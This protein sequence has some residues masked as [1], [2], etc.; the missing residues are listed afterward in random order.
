MKYNATGK[1]EGETGTRS[2]QKLS[3]ATQSASISTIA[4]AAAPAA[5]PAPAPAAPTPAAPAAT[6]KRATPL[7]DMSITLL[8]FED[9]LADC[10]IGRNELLD[11]LAAAGA[12]STR[13]EKLIANKGPVRVF[14]QKF[15]LE[16]AIGFHACS[17][18]AS[19]RV[20]IGTPLGC[21]PL[22][23][24]H[25]VNCVQTLKVPPTRCRVSADIHQIR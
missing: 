11:L 3:T 17:L 8:K 18:Q 15:T 12:D 14:R 4:P 6:E 23:P 5:A 10:G 21:S 16:D 9:V 7:A 20:T 22:L 13:V 1:P 2:S 19:R 24:V 25:A